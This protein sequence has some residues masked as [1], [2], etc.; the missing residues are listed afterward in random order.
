MC[1]NCHSQTDTY[2]GKTSNTVKITSEGKIQSDKIKRL[3]S[4]QERLNLIKNIDLTKFGWIEKVSY[5]WGVS[6]AQVRRLFRKYGKEIETFNRKTN[7]PSP[8]GMAS[9]FGSDV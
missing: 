8:N 7:T 6:H 4:F 3:S 1:P 5:V 2:A 9:D